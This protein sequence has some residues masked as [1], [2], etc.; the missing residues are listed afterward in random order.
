MMSSSSSFFN[1]DAF[2]GFMVILLIAQFIV[3]VVQ[4]IGAFVRTVIRLNKG[5]GLG[6][7]KTYWIMVGVYFLVFGAMYGIYLYLDSS[8]NNMDFTIEDYGA[9]QRKMEA[10]GTLAKI[11]VVWGLTAWFIAVWYNIKVVFYKEKN[12][13]QSNA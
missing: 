6:H 11:A 9:Y 13:T 7:L 2:F 8:S 5:K 1:S 10:I 3:G 4:L 12:N